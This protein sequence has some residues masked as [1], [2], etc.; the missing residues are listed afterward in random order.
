MSHLKSEFWI[1]YSLSPTLVQSEKWNQDGGD[2]INF[3]LYN[4]V[5]HTLPAISALVNAFC[6]Y[7]SFNES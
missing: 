5:T 3:H 2:L 6:E 4:N 7:E 1:L